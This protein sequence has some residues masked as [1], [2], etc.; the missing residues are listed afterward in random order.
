MNQSSFCY[1]SVFSCTIWRQ[2]CAG[3]QRA[4]L[5]PVLYHGGSSPRAAPLHPPVAPS[6]LRESEFGFLQRPPLTLTSPRP[7][8]RSTAPPLSATASTSSVQLHS[9]PRGCME[10]LAR[11]L[12]LIHCHGEL[13]K[14]WWRADGPQSNYFLSDVA[15]PKQTTCPDEASVSVAVSGITEELLQV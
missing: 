1:I 10:T 6:G 3:A 14:S 5:T 9:R 15:Y 11:E 2:M 4:Y 8:T 13:M 12:A 7:K